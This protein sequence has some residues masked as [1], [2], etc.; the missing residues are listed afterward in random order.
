MAPE[1]G[2]ITAPESCRETELCTWAIEVLDNTIAGENV[3]IRVIDGPAGIWG[4]TEGQGISFIPSLGSTAQQAE[5][6]VVLDD[7]LGGTAEQ[8]LTV[9]IEPRTDF[10]GL[11]GE[12]G[13]LP[14]AL[15]NQCALFEIP[16]SGFVWVDREDYS[17]RTIHNDT[18]D[19]TP[20]SELPPSKTIPVAVDHNVASPFLSCHVALAPNGGFFILETTTQTLLHYGANG[21]FL[22]KVALS[23]VSTGVEVFAPLAGDTYVFLDTIQDFPFASLYFIDVMQLLDTAYGTLEEAEE[24]TSNRTGKIALSVVTPADWSSEYLWIG[25][26]RIRLESTVQRIGFVDFSFEGDVLQRR[27]SMKRRSPEWFQPTL[28]CIC[29]WRRR[30]AD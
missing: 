13:A 3:S 8:V 21:S 2:E 12:K 30:M 23:G 16:G 29:R 6:T 11:V 5:F 14:S 22:R 25:P 7:G 20:L 26:D 17:V 10:R 27:C 4:D 1:F 24:A 9:D 28:N 15:G 19:L 18:G